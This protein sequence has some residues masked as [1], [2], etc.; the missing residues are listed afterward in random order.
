MQKLNH[1]KFTSLTKIMKSKG[2]ND[3]IFV[4]KNEEQKKIYELYIING[5]IEVVY[6]P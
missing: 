1:D 5:M 6:Y 2:I 4:K 3:I